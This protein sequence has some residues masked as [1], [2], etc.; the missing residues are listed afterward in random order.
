MRTLACGC[1]LVAATIVIGAQNGNGSSPAN[2]SGDTWPGVWGPSRN[3]T[4]MTHSSR[5][6]AFKE[7]WR[8]KT[9]GGYSEVA[10]TPRG[11]FTAEARD[12]HDYVLAV[13]PATGS[14]R[15]RF[16]FGPTYRGHDGSHDGPIATP[17]VDGNDL[18]AVGPHGLL[19]A[20]D[21]ATGQERWRHDLVR[22]FGASAM[23]Y[24]FGSSPLVDGSQVIVQTSGEKSRGLMAFNRADGTLRWHVARGL[25]G[26]YSSPSIGTLAGTRQIIASAGDLVYAVSP[27]DGR[28]LWSVKGPG[29]GE[30][31]ANPP[32]ILS[33]DRVLI[34]FWGEA[35]LLKIA[36]QEQ[37]LTATETWRSP[38]LRGAYSPSVQR[39]ESLF[40]FNGPFLTCL[41]LAT[42]DVRWRHRTYEGTLIGV[43]DHLLV[44]GR[45]SGNLHVVE[46]SPAG[47]KEV[48]ST[49]V[50]TPGATGMTGPSFAGSRVFV[51][52]A[53]EIVALAMEGR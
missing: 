10:V 26:G 36:R 4:T 1:L 12:G 42:G 7:L 35:V 48:A 3:G 41:D 27:T 25:R 51:R 19:V 14:E 2:G 5:P 37:E 43:G 6:A 31:V 29:D 24:G 18:Y 15:W 46:A 17:A 11:A 39:G 49:P 53:E 45:G 52:N 13:D 44:L 40:G 8:R 30:Q 23:I 34:T 20:L 47:Y 9:Q 32:Q 22:E 16:S 38:R 33:D 21:A 50:L 28:I